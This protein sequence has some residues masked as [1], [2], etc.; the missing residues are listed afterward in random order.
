M[1][2][3]LSARMRL[4]IVTV[5][6][7]FVRTNLQFKHLKICIPWLVKPNEGKNKSRVTY[8][9]TQK[10]ARGDVQWNELEIGLGETPTGSAMDATL[11]TAAASKPRVTLPA[12]APGKRQCT[13][14]CG[15]ACVLNQRQKICLVHSLVRKEKQESQREESVCFFTRLLIYQY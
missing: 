11:L 9:N 14:K 3:A 5:N 13:K 6:T 1:S 4:T 7:G 2:H 15:L 12:E 8:L 10:P